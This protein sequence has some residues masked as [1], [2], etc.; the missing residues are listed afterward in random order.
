MCFGILMASTLTSFFPPHL[1]S[2]VCPLNA[3]FSASIPSFIGDSILSSLSLPLSGKVQDSN[4][5]GSTPTQNTI[6]SPTSSSEKNNA[7][8]TRGTVS[9]IK[10]VIG[11]ISTADVPH[12]AST[13]QNSVSISGKDSEEAVTKV[14][15]YTRVKSR[16]SQKS[17]ALEKIPNQE[18][19]VGKVLITVINQSP[20][21]TSSEFD[22]EDES[23]TRAVTRISQ[24]SGVKDKQ[25]MNSGGKMLDLERKRKR[26]DSS[27]TS[28]RS[29][30]CTKPQEVESLHADLASCMKH[31]LRVIIPKLEIKVSN[32]TVLL[33]T[34]SS[35]AAVSP[36]EP[37]T[38]GVSAARTVDAA[39]RKRKRSVSV[40]PEKNLTGNIDKQ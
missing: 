22:E 38:E 13:N 36:R 3:P 32:Q 6:P 4:Q 1:V 25:G 37:V 15:N 30:Q 28:L 12:D 7:R 8:R 33:S 24:R 34:M 5:S 21:H 2:L 31:Q 17:E 11:S 35:N 19:C 26:K 14:S 20:T 27:Q 10:P 39:N 40:T 16:S 23:Q 18:H 9:L 29:S